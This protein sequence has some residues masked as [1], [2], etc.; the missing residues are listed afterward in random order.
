M[1]NKHS[2]Q[3]EKSIYLRNVA[4]RWKSELETDKKVYI[5]SPYITSKTA[6]N[7]L[8]NTISNYCEIYTLLDFETFLNGGSSI[9]T[10]KN[11]INKGIKV[12]SIQ[13]LHAKIILI[14]DKFVSIGS[15]NLT[16]QGTRNKEATFTSTDEKIVNFVER[17]IKKNWLNNCKEITLEMLE[18]IEKSIKPIKKKHKNLIGEIEK[19][20]EFVE[21]QETQRKAERH[22][23]LERQQEL[24]LQ[25]EY[26]KR[27][28]T[29]RR[30]L[31]EFDKTHEVVR[32]HLEV[33]GNYYWIRSGVNTFIPN[34][35][36]DNDLLN[37]KIGKE[38]LA[39]EKTYRYL[40]L[41]ED[42]GKLAW[43]RVM[44]TRI[45]KYENNIRWNDQIDLN[46]KKYQI[47]F[48]A[49]WNKETLANYN[50]EINLEKKSAFYSKPEKYNIQGWFDFEKLSIHKIE[51]LEST[52]E[53]IEWGKNNKD[54]F[55]Q[56][57]IKKLLNPFKYEK[58]LTGSEADSFL[59]T[60]KSYDLRVR[61]IKNQKFLSFKQV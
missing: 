57:I 41:I 56:I 1:E 43:V 9:K 4:R 2:A 54:E 3:S 59:K 26:Q 11:L 55:E 31:E 46:N 22:K 58:N 42:T 15:Q 47:I 10:L 29:I 51:S 35:I 21:E 20:K 30:K 25:K 52:D 48:R 37:W 36:K 61:R 28:Y 24:E 7:V 5:L 40:A 53:L 49:N 27:L 38:K 39:L 32:G 60:G 14:S 19:A 45:T 18:D 33:K 50:I 16:N 44:K 12:Y 13:N 23:E 17:E 8:E 6:E 34:S